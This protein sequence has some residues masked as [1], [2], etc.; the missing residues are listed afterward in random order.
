VPET[1]QIPLD[2]RRSPP[3]AAWCASPPRAT[4]R[5][6]PRSWCR[7]P[8]EQLV[9]LGDAL[10]VDQQIQH[11]DWRA[12]TDVDAGLAERSRAALL[13]TWR[14]ARDRRPSARA[15]AAREN[16]PEGDDAHH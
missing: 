14:L 7:I 9:L 1:R 12:T 13:T 2:G 10:Y 3:I 6:T 4:R 5:G 8:G 16:T 15:L 11:R